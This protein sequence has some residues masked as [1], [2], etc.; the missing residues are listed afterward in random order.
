[1]QPS[2]EILRSAFA[3]RGFDLLRSKGR[4]VPNPTRRL[5]ALSGDRSMTPREALELLAEIGG[6]I[7]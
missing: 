7:D 2:Y 5:G 1:M 4:T 6:P 3:Q